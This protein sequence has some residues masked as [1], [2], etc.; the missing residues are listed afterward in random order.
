MVG[1][2]AFK[3][4]KHIR[5]IVHN[6]FWSI[7]PELNPDTGMIKL[8]SVFILELFRRESLQSSATLYPGMFIDCWFLECSEPSCQ[9][10]EIASTDG[11]FGVYLVN[12]RHTKT[13]K[14][15]Q[16]AL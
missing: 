13:A 10:R 5:N 9:Q 2:V 14:Y 3:M 16:F 12:L 4:R 15:L 1:Q 6:E 7:S 11:S 8:E